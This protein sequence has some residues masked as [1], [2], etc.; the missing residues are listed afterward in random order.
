MDG[1]V[2]K[3]TGDL[4]HAD[5]RYEREL[6]AEE[7]FRIA[8]F[9]IEHKP[10]L[11]M[12]QVAYTYGFNEAT[13]GRYLTRDVD[14]VV[15]QPLSDE[16]LA[17]IRDNPRTFAPANP[18]YQKNHVNAPGT[19]RQWFRQMRAA[20][21]ERELSRFTASE[22]AARATGNAE[23]GWLLFDTMKVVDRETAATYRAN[24]WWYRS[25]TIYPLFSSKVHVDRGAGAAFTL[26]DAIAATKR[27]GAGW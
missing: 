8:S 1:E 25:P 18:Y 10:E 4:L 20:D 19:V 12:L 26:A 7:A 17:W 5:H 11:R 16:L 9:G 13:W 21:F 23:G 15:E 2:I 14:D 27:R 3:P 6:T 22:L 24:N